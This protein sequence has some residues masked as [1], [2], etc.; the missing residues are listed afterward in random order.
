MLKYLPDKP[1]NLSLI[2][3]THVEKKSR[4]GSVVHAY[5]SSVEARQAGLP[6][7]LA[8]VENSGSVRDSDSKEKG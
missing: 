2:P 8:S 5:F 6:A 7:R 1:E 3:S 4:C